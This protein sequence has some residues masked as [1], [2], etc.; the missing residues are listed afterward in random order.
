MIAPLLP[1]VQHDLNSNTLIVYR[2]AQ[3]KFNLFG[4]AGKVES[5]NLILSQRVFSKAGSIEL[6]EFIR[7]QALATAEVWENT[8]LPKTLYIKFYDWNFILLAN[9]DNVVSEDDLLNGAQKIFV[10]HDVSEQGLLDL[11]NELINWMK[12]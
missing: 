7:D 6:L 1:N 5:P 4:T 3:Y 11:V 8:D 10:S 12:V 2:E 9:D